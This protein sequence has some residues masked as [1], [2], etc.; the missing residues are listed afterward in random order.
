[1]SHRLYTN[2]GERFSKLVGDAPRDDASARQCEINLVGFLR[3]AEIERTSLFEGSLLAER[4][5][6]VPASRD[7]DV[8]TARRKFG[9]LVAS[10][11]VGAG[12]PIDANFG[13]GNPHLRATQ[14]SA[15]VCRDHTAA[16]AGC[17]C[18]SWC[19]RS[20]AW[21]HRRP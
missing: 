16:N 15:I 9:K 10:F 21:L 6:H 19:S 4:E 14:G 17:A 18:R 8:V 13:S 3:S 1:M 12:N 5:R 7:G 20:I 11:G 2:T